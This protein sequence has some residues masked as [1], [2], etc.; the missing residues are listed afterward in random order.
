MQIELPPELEP[1]VLQE[2]ATGRYAT[3]E[4]VV[5]KSLRRLREERQEAVSGIK[6]GLDECG[7]R[8]DS[9]RR[10]GFC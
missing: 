5:A 8:S 3:P 9:A 2:F 10:G 1:F 7:R 4:A 6:Q